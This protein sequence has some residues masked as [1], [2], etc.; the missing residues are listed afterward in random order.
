MPPSYQHLKEI[1]MYVDELVT[2][3]AKR[4][5]E[6][7]GTGVM[8]VKQ[9]VGLR[10]SILSLSPNPQSLSPSLFENTYKYT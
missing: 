7:G 8:T 1:N 9:Y 3:L 2:F 4:N 6:L 10:R 5:I